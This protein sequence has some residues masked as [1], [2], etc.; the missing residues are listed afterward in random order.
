MAEYLCMDGPLHGHALEWPD[1]VD[2]GGVLT[3]AMIDVGQ[4]EVAPHDEPEADYRIERPALDGVPG[5]LRFVAGRGPWGAASAPG[6]AATG[7]PAA[8]AG[9]LGV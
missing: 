6:A 4:P 1:G 8:T 2:P 9:L 5:R 7:V 3:V